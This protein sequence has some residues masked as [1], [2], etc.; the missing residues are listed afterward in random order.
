MK[1]KTTIDTRRFN[2]FYD[3]EPTPTNLI[4]PITGSILMDDGSDMHVMDSDH[5]YFAS[6]DKNIKFAR[7]PFSW[8]LF[9]QIEYRHVGEHGIRF[10]YLLSDNTW[11]EYV[12]DKRINKLFPINT[13]QSE[14][15]EY[16]QNEEKERQE[17]KRL[18][19]EGVANGTITPSPNA[20]R[21]VSRLIDQEKVT[22]RPLSPPSRNL[23]YTNFTYKE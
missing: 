14:I 16:I 1:K 9:R 20:T 7:H 4:C 23:F 10:F 2:P 3:G 18:Y 5:F 13:P 22:V 15:E 21:V 11:E 8:N 12:G 19:D 6:S 17:R